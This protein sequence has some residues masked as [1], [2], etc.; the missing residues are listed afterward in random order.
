MTD[1]KT[2]G[3]VYKPV[4]RCIYCD[5]RHPDFPLGKE[6]IIPFSLDGPFIL[7]RASCTQ[8]SR[9][10]RDFETA[11]ART[12]FGPYRLA[13]GMPTRNPH[14][15][16]SHLSAFTQHKNRT[17]RQERRIP[18]SEYP[19]ISVAIP[20][21]PPPGLL[22]G[23]PSSEE[24]M[25]VPR[26]LNMAK[27]P[28]WAMNQGLTFERTCPTGKF[29]QL[30]AKIAHSYASAELGVDSFDP[31]LP[32][33][34]VGNA[35]NLPDFVGGTGVPSEGSGAFLGPLGTFFPFLIEHDLRFETA[36]APNGTRYLLVRIS[37]ISRFIPTY[38][39][40][41]AKA[42]PGFVLR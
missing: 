14:E 4:W 17:A 22:L 31:L 38:R 1:G 16:P 9:K 27:V 12:M 3:K 35:T 10:T 7:P 13:S 42:P 24:F 20:E 23:K 15:R 26:I 32:P 2:G 29:A 18:L 19:I 41:V 33:L 37:L 40:I 11:C 21:L 6:H 8:C 25:V 39:V 28:H 5:R 36:R 34:I 30:L